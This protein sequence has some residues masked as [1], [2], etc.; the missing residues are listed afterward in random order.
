MISWRKQST[1]IQQNGYFVFGLTPKLNLSVHF[2]EQPV[3]ADYTV[4]E[5]VR[6]IDFYLI[7]FMIFINSIPITLQA[8]T[9]K[10]SVIVR[11]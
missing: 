1:F 2:S 11:H 10:V 7:A 3:S 4:G 8:S 9:Y 6:T 5:A